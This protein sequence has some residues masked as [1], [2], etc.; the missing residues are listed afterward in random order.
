MGK[1]SM[2]MVAR[3]RIALSGALVLALVGCALHGTR[4]DKAQVPDYSVVMQR[5]QARYEA[6]DFNG[7]K[8]LYK[9]ATKADPTRSAPWYRLAQIHF[10]E[11]NYGRA[12]VDSREVLRRD[13][14]DTGAQSI[15]TISG[16]RVSIEALGLMQSQSGLH[17]TA[18]EVAEK[19]ASKMREVLGQ[20]VLVPPAS[21][22]RPA[23]RR[24]VRRASQAR[25]PASTA[26]SS[27]SQ[28]ETPSTPSTNPFLSL[29]GGRSSAD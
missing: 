5:A 10:D 20:D 17:G 2:E 27:Q 21:S 29:P 12:I 15:L 23:K 8:E 13:P 14:S 25:K 18:H 9:E 4:P 11:Q 19:L 28:S 24:P 3:A 26:A 7:A 22:P 1:G 6:R 16:L